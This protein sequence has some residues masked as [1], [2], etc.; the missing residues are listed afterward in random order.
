MKAAR[1][2]LFA[3]MLAAPF[4]AQAQKPARVG[5][6]FLAS[7]AATAAH[8]EMLRASLREL[9]WTDA[10]L[11]LELVSADGRAERLPA[12]AARLVE[13][14]VDLIVTGGGNVS[15]IAARKATASIPIVM[16]GSV[17]AVEAGL[18][19]SLARPGG[20]VTGL[21]VP[22]ELA[23]KQLELLRELVPSLARLAILTRS[24]ISSPE[25][26]ARTRGML[27]LIGIVAEYFDVE[28]RSDLPRAFAAMR[29]WKPHALIV[30]PDP[31]ILD[32]S[33]A[34]VE[35]QRAARLPAMHPG[36]ELVD[37]GG[38]ISFSLSPREVARGVARH[39]DRILRGARPAG[40]PVEQPTTFELVI[41][42]RTARALG[43]AVPQSVL[44][45]AD[46]VIE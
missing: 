39:V 21:T 30:G 24:S 26:R 7:P 34:L 40:L 43:L 4:A 35:F 25:Q 10:R 5:L 28:E 15:T 19:E 9:G 32:E 36:R 8:V 1:A 38:L 41:N 16:T 33:A 13:R 17:G 3:C 12:L 46:Q 29:A 14:R 37:A 6:L 23:E 31:L 2:L 44:L 20:N 45:R 42:L 18:V 27:E 11:T 22:R